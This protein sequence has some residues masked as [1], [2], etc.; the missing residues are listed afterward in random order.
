[1]DAHM[2]GFVKHIVKKKKALKQC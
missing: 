2:K 1:V